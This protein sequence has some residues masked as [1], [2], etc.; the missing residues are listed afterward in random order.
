MFSILVG[1]TLSLIVLFAAFIGIMPP[2]EPDDLPAT[3]GPRPSPAPGSGH[4][5]LPA[6]IPP[7]AS[8]NRTAP[9]PVPAPRPSGG[10]GG[11]TTPND[12]RRD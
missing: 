8:A 1:V 9:V 10:E 6:R 3:K 12:P 4:R 11:D 7:M 2:P 5:E